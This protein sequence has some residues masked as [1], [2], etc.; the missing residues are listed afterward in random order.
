MIQG[1]VLGSA[2]RE[3]GFTLIELLIAMTITLLIAGALASV[4][5]PARAAF[6]RVPAELDL[7]QRA[8]TAIDALSQALRSAGRNVAAPDGLGLLS[9][10][11]P[12]ASVS[13]PDE[14]GPFTELTVIVPVTDAAQGILFRDQSETGGA[15]QLATAPCPDVADVCGFTIGSPA[16]IADGAGNYD[17][18]IVAA[19]NPGARLVT[20]AGALSRSYPAGSVVVEAN[21]FTFSLAQQADG[22]YSLIR[23]TAAG[24]VQPVVDFVSSLT[25]D[26]IGRNV[27][28]GFFQLEQVDV[29]IGVE[30]PRESLRRLM[31]DRV[32]RTSI[33]LRNAS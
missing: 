9:D 15:I 27:P 16:V 6:D 26:V 25:F 13:G 20:P 8:R 32:F 18:F 23:R 4:V 21:E 31:T 10:I 1:F 14:S 30:P 2:K 33:R 17:V 11:V 3:G 28:A 5:Q 24:A 19:T 7:Q 22:S 12:T 29:S